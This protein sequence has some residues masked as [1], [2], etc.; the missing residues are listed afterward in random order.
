MDIFG[1]S[2]NLIFNPMVPDPDMRS[3]T[4]ERAMDG[5]V[6]PVDRNEGV[7]IEEIN[8]DDEQERED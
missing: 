3:G 5:E 1:F 7:F 2:D 4:L 6:F 8:E